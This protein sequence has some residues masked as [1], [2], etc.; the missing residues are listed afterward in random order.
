MHENQDLGVALAEGGP[1][2]CLRRPFFSVD[3]Y[4]LR[5]VLPEHIER[6]RL[7]RNAQMDI[8]R[9]SHLITPTQ[10]VAYYRDHVWPA[11]HMK[12]PPHILLAF[13]QDDQLIGYGGLVHIAWEHRRA[14]VSFL[15]NPE[16]EQDLKERSA[17]LSVYLHLLK[18][19]A[20]DDLQLD[21]LF[22]ETYAMRSYHIQTLEAEGFQYE[23]CLRAHVWMQ[24]RPVDSVFHG[25]LSPRLQATLNTGQTVFTE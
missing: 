15:L 20:F 3:G 18:E 4:T 7:W 5:A 1:Y 17:L 6:L 2:V 10:Q 23:G 11:K 24:G 12:K 16:Y 19:L 25:C 21:R 13:F 8:L 14:E 22:T 9:Q